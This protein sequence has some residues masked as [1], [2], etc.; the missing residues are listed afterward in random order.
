MGSYAIRSTSEPIQA[1]SLRKPAASFEN[2]DALPSGE[3]KASSQ[4]LEMSIPMVR[5][6]LLISSSLFLCLSCEPRCSCI[7]SGRREGRWRPKLPCGPLR[8]SDPAVR[9][10]SLVGTRAGARYARLCGCPNSRA[11]PVTRTCKSNGHTQEWKRQATPQSEGL[12][13]VRRQVC[14]HNLP[15]PPRGRSRPA[16]PPGRVFDDAARRRINQ[17][18]DCPAGIGSA[19]GED[20]ARSRRQ[21][22]LWEAR[23]R[24]P[25]TSSLESESGSPG[26]WGAPDREFRSPTR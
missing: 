24:L 9:P 3:A 1:I 13:R 26:W 2:R 8:P 17:F 6:M 12:V 7:H 14:L 15:P 19:T 11:F 21:R 5:R 10:P 22:R 4:S 20:P 18:A 16:I 25:G 23:L